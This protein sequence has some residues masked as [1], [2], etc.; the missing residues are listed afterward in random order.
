MSK[1]V[2][3]FF[4]NIP[5]G[6]TQAYRICPWDQTNTH[7]PAGKRIAVK[8]QVRSYGLG[9][10]HTKLYQLVQFPPAPFSPMT[11]MKNLDRDIPD[12]ILL[13]DREPADNQ[14]GEIIWQELG[15]VDEQDSPE[16]V[17]S[18]DTSNNKYFLVEVTNLETVDFPYSLE[19]YVTI[20]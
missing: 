10:L 1:L 14:Q 13:I 12:N 15:M 18:Q 7:V 4:E 8:V 11:A 3:S 16:F 2:Q 5:A 6:T 19:V 17:I 20:V 9:T